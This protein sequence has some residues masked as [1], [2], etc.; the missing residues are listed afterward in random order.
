[1]QKENPDPKV[2][3][4]KPK[5]NRRQIS[6]LQLEQFIYARRKFKEARREYE[7]IRREIQQELSS[8][9]IIQLG[10]HTASIIN[11]ERLFIA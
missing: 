2:V 6:Q 5:E 3:T 10:A 4:F 7:Q 9:A 8:G 11:L 1:M